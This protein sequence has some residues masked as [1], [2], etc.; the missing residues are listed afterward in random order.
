[1]EKEHL[2]GKTLYEL[3]MVAAEMGMPR[4]AAKQMAQWLYIKRVSEISAMSNISLQH[5]ER[6]SQ[7]YDIGRVAPM[8]SHRSVDGTVKYLFGIDKGDFVET[9]YI[10]DRERATLCV[11]SQVGCKMNCH[12]CMTGKQGFKRSLSSAEIINQILSVENSDQLTNLVFMGMG[13]PFDNLD[14]VMKALEILTADWGFAWS[15]KRITVSTIG[16]LKGISRFLDESR[17]HLAVSLHSPYP[18][19]R[20]QIM[21]IE[22]AYPMNDVLD[23]L[24][25]YDFSHQRR[26]SFEYILFN[27]YNDDLAHAD[28]LAR[29]LRGLDCRVNL[30]RFH[31]IP[32]VELKSSDLSSMEIFRDRLNHHGVVATIR[33]SRGEDIFAACGML[34]TAEKE[35]K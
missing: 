14:E 20:L 1:M 2:L 7:R 17:C 21:P 32:G 25:T 3:Q 28:A 19:E 11:S 27:G 23:F 10:P 13:E 29:V 6:L 5:R 9:V 35:K 12:F 15:P 22:R 34:S 26:L 8:Q 31:A 18:Q 33:A 30:I 24:R 4:F 16:H